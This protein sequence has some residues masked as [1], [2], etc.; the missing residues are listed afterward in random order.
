M[1]R[2]TGDDDLTSEFATTWRTYDLDAKTA[3]LLE[4]AEK[5]TKAPGM[6]DDD[7]IDALRAAGW[8]EDAIYEAS[9]LISFFNFSGRME[10]ASGLPADEVP[11]SARPRE[12]RVAAGGPRWRPFG[13]SSVRSRSDAATTPRPRA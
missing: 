10:A 12:A 11:A 1:R 2:L 8:S 5:L 7:D 4:Y 13:R 9:A 6:I 3:S